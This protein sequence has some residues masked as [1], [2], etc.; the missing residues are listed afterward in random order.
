MEGRISSALEGVKD[1][2]P[3]FQMYEYIYKADNDLEKDLR[4]KILL[5]Y[6][7]FIDLSI[8]I[9]RYYLRPGICK[10]S[11]CPKQDAV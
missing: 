4:K 10:S 5:A 1:R 6:L 11:L 9:T 2:L 7:E 3:G 8:E